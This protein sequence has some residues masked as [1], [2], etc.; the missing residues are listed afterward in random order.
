VQHQL[1]FAYFSCKCVHITLETKDKQI[2][3]PLGYQ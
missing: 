1:K 3:I 2:L